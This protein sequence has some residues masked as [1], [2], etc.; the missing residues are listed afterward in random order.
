[1][2]RVVVGNCRKFGV[3][4]NGLEHDYVGVVKSSFELR[5]GDSVRFVLSG[6]QVIEDLFPLFLLGA[7]IL[8]GGWKAPSWN[9]KGISLST[10]LGTGT[11]SRTVR[12]RRESEVE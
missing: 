7:Y 12:F 4:G 11:V 10:D 2:Y 3:P 9:Y 8:C 1:M 5:V 6:L